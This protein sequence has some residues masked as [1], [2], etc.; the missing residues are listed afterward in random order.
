MKTIIVIYGSRSTEHSV[1]INSAKNVINGL[2]KTKYHIVPVYISQKGVWNVLPPIKK[3]IQDKKELQVEK[4]ISVSESIKDFLT[5]ADGH[6]VIVFPVIHGAN[7]EDAAIQGFLDMLNLPY[8]GNSALSSATCFHKGV[9]N[10]LFAAH[11]IPQADYM[12][13]HKED[14]EKDPSTI[15]NEIVIFGL[16]LYVKPCN[17]GSSI[18]VTPVYEEEELENALKTAFSYDTHI[19]LEK[20]IIGRE[21][22]V[23]VIGADNPITSLPG[24]YPREGFFDYYGKYKAG[25]LDPIIPARLTAAGIDEVRQLAINAY[26][27]ARCTGFARVDIFVDKHEN[28]YVNE[29]NTIPG[30]SDS[31]MTPQIWEPTDGTT[32]PQFLEKLI[33][34]A[35]KRYRELNA[36]NRQGED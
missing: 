28:F 3:S 27:A 25:H 9:T 18:G 19:V 36:L 32:F 13:L 12:E 34:L 21:L 6:D 23:S 7:G 30:M 26:K 29:I 35:E 31:S 17:A 24:E 15:L 8:I 4:E 14:Y 33:A 10:D 5:I 16:P 22:Q 1:S 20:E 2:D 11:E